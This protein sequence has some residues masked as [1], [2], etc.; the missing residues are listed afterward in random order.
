M[1]FWR[2]HRGNKP[3]FTRF[4]SAWLVK[5]QSLYRSPVRES[6]RVSHSSSRKESRCSFRRWSPWVNLSRNYE[7]LM[8]ANNFSMHLDCKEED[9]F[10]KHWLIELW[11]EIHI[12]WVWPV[13]YDN[14]GYPRSTRRKSANIITMAVLKSPLLDVF[15]LLRLAWKIQVCWQS[16]KRSWK[17]FFGFLWITAKLLKSPITVVRTSLKKLKRTQ[18]FISA[19]NHK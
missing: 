7:F 2:H 6:Y 8:S 10:H 18:S 11:T 5:C 13:T 16:T 14:L 4:C 12:Q 9:N 1:F 15:Q 17:T 3:I 19:R